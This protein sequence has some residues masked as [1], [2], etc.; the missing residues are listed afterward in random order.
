MLSKA[1]ARFE[2]ER[3]AYPPEQFVDVDYR[4]FVS[5]PGRDHEG[6]LRVLRPRV[7]AGG[8]R[9]GHQA[10][11]RV[12]PGRPPAQALLRPR[13]LRAHRGRGAGGVRVT[14]MR[15]PWRGT[16]VMLRTLGTS[17]VP[18]GQRHVVR[19]EHL[20]Q[21]G[22]ALHQRE[23]GADAA[24]YAAPEGDPGVGGDLALEEP[25]RPEPGVVGMAGL[26]LV[27]EDDRGR[28]VGAR[29]RSMPPTVAGA[30]RWRTTIGITGCSAHRLLEH[31]LEVVGRRRPTRRPGP[32]AS[33]SGSLPS[34]CSVQASAVAV[35]SW[36]ASRSVTSWSRSSSS[37]RPGTVLVARPAAAG[38]VRRCR[39]AR[40][41]AA[42]TLGDHP[43]RSPGPARPGS[44]SCAARGRTS[45]ASGSPSRG[46]PAAGCSR[47][48]SPAGAARR[49]GPR[50]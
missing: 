30:I 49:A 34:S 22:H 12:T 15:A 7:D 50:R 36:P 26:R 10:R 2:R 38:R 8:R 43:R 9:G 21:D 37:V 18:G 31:R 14:T 11:R 5:R 41:V 17:V 42:A 3:A 24:A 29:G 44:R 1:V 6:H 4:E 40:S 23:A 46:T 16:L 39:S 19:R 20:A 47:S 13:R 25:L 48:C 28:D 32:C 45:A 35:V 33:C 27:G